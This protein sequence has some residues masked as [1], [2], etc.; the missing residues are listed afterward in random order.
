MDNEEKVKLGIYTTGAKESSNDIDSV[1]ES[2]DK[3][4]KKNKNVSENLEKNNIFKKGL[5]AGAIKQ[6]AQKIVEFA[7]KSADY[8]ETLN[9]LDVAFNNNTNSIKQFTNAIVK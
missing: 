1:T 6:S 5:L 7:K 9:V 2:L 3:L 4:D 8:V